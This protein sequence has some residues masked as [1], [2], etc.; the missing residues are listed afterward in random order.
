MCFETPQV[1]Y[2]LVVLIIANTLVCVFIDYI[3]GVKK[4]NKKGKKY[5]LGFIKL[6]N[7][8]R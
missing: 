5:G 6:R 3:L 7:S 1:Y 4:I 8:R 2:L